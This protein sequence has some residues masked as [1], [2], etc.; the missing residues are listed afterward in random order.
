LNTFDL[1]LAS[2]LVINTAKGLFKGFIMTA[3]SLTGMVLSL[4]AARIYYPWLADILKTNLN[5]SGFIERLAIK[6]VLTNPPSGNGFAKLPLPPHI[7]EMF[8][9][10]LENIENMAAEGIQNLQALLIERLTEV[11]FNLISFFIILFIVSVA[12]KI[13]AAFLQS[14]LVNDL[15]KGINRMLGLAAG[16]LEG[17]VLGLVFVIAASF[18]LTLGNFQ[19][20]LLSFQS[21]RLVP[22][23]FMYD[24]ITPW[25]TRLMNL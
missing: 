10:S 24:F 20:M 13:F 9:P 5:I 14:M 11:I 8:L 3:A 15:I 2:L 17:G 1:I 19:G 7:Q 6:T 12:I 23:F 4:I 16:F 21:S 25:L 18:V 22:Y